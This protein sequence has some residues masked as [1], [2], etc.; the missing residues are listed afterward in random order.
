MVRRQALHEVGGIQSIRGNLIDD[1][2]LAARIKE[3]GAVWLGLTEET[4]SLRAYDRLSEVW[5]MVARAA[6]TQLN[7]SP[8]ALLVTM[9]GMVVIYGAPP[10]AAVYGLVEMNAA[11]GWLG[12]VA[13]LI[14][15]VAYRPTLRLYRLP[16][17]WGLLLPVAA[18]LFTLM[19]IDSA[20]LHWRGRGGQWK[21]RSY[22]ETGVTGG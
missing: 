16:V 10:V 18:L 21:G 2:A 4:R 6:F 3:Q 15:A 12:G 13:W 14:M 1:C 19:T 9:F 5:K 8:G 22:N 7:H 17:W 20:R 11:A